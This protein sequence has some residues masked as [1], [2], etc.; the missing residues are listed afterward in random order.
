MPMFA[1]QGTYPTPN[2]SMGYEGGDHPLG[3]MQDAAST[4]APTSHQEHGQFFEGYPPQ[5]MFTPQGY[6]TSTWHVSRTP[7]PPQ[8]F[9]GRP[10]IPPG[11]SSHK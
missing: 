5:P 8:G 7:M 1:Q 2:M 11:G 3:G 9:V 4:A 6:P 10:E